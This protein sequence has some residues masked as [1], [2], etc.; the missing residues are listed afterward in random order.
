M[1]ITLSHLW[2]GCFSFS[3]NKLKIYASGQLIFA[4]WS[5]LVIYVAFLLDDNSEGEESEFYLNHYRVVKRW[6][7]IFALIGFEYTLD[8]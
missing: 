7:K 4:I 1:I 5:F 2:K 8:I 3:F 6:N